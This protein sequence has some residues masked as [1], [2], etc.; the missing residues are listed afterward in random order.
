METELLQSGGRFYPESYGCRRLPWI[1]ELHGHDLLPLEYGNRLL[2]FGRIDESLESGEVLL[3]ELD[4]SDPVSTGLVLDDRGWFVSSAIPQS[5]STLL[6][7]L[8]NT[9]ERIEGWERTGS[10]PVWVVDE[11]GAVLEFAVPLG[12]WT[13]GRSHHFMKAANGWLI[14]HRRYER[15]ERSVT[16]GLY[17]VGD[18]N[19]PQL[20]ETGIIHSPRLSP[21]GCS[22]GY[23]YA[24]D[25]DVGIRTKLHIADLCR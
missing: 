15:S 1:A 18:D 11:A 2:D 25:S 4:G 17:F 16:G 19:Q 21:D 24:P 23:L 22:V 9:E 10:I 7:Q 20:I 5:R 8:A 3:R 12:V 6:F 14:S 13:Q